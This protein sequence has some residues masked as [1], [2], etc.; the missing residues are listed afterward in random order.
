MASVWQRAVYKPPK[1]IISKAKIWNRRT[2]PM[3]YNLK[4]TWVPQPLVHN[5]V[6]QLFNEKSFRDFHKESQRLFV[7]DFREGIKEETKKHL[8][9]DTKSRLVETVSDVKGEFLFQT[10]LPEEAYDSSAMLDYGGNLEN[11]SAV[12]RD[13]IVSSLDESSAA[14]FSS[15]D[16]RD[17]QSLGSYY[18]PDTKSVISR[19]S[20]SQLSKPRDHQKTAVKDQSSKKPGETPKKETRAKGKKGKTSTKRSQPGESEEKGQTFLS[21]PPARGD[22]VATSSTAKKG[23]QLQIRSRSHSNLVIGNS[24]IYSPSGMSVQSTGV[25]LRHNLSQPS[26]NFPDFMDETQP[27]KLV[28][29]KDV[30][31]TSNNTIVVQNEEMHRKFRY[32]PLGRNDAKIDPMHPYGWR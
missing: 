27:G 13:S 3:H 21:Q 12:D 30:F 10:Q 31:E 5:A 25:S 16:E 22:T 26:I 7:K 17:N 29:S 14:S 20:K 15:Q 9:E 6:N 24:N 18:D 2:A 1:K 19:G 11:D 8:F 28:K 32:R 4:Y 23:D